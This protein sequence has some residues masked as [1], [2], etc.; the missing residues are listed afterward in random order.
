VKDVRVYNRGWSHWGH[1]LTLRVVERD[2]P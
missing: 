2:K 1:E